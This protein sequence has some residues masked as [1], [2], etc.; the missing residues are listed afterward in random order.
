MCFGESLHSPGFWK[1]NS[2][3]LAE[4]QYTKLIEKTIADTIV[5]NNGPTP[6]LLFDTIK[7][8]V[9]GV[10][11]NYSSHKKRSDNIKFQDWNNKLTALQ[12]RLLHATS[13]EER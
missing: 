8:R 10:M 1:F 2:T 7:C 9:R 13:K 6:T 12:E 5:E 4:T 3:L 11:V